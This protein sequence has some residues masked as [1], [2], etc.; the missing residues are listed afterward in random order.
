M[1][2]ERRLSSDEQQRRNHARPSWEQAF[3]RLDLKTSHE[4]ELNELLKE[5]RFLIRDYFEAIIASARGSYRRL[6]RFRK[7]YEPEG[8]PSYDSRL[9]YHMREARSIVHGPRKPH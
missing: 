7:E 3:Q 1:P 2:V 4:P 8:I 6:R 5:N 9:S